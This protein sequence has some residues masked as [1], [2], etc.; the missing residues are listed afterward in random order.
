MARFF[1]NQEENRSQS[2]RRQTKSELTNSRT[3]VDEMMKSSEFW[4]S[5]LSVLSKQNINQEAV[6][7]IKSNMKI[8]NGICFKDDQSKEN[9]PS[10]KDS[11]HKGGHRYTRSEYLE[12]FGQESK[13]EQLKQVIIRKNNLTG[14]QSNKMLTQEQRSE[15]E[16]V[17]YPEQQLSEIKVG[18][19]DYNMQ[20]LLSESSLDV[21]GKH[22]TINKL[23]VSQLTNRSK[24]SQKSKQAY[25]DLLNSGQQVV[26]E[27]T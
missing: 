16:K 13:I 17:D 9:G 24:I 4:K 14:T 20:N 18:A 25:L 11:C 7:N 6:L 8:G 27:T 19:N 26:E 15:L 23:K 10:Y 5:Q 2:R 12:A 22:S 21:V 3:A 1:I